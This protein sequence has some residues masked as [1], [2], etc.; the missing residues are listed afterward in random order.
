MILDTLVQAPQYNALSP[1]F[2]PAFAFL[3]QVHESTPLGRHEIAGEE[4]FA[5]VQQHATK[6]V[7]ERKFEAHRKYIDIQYIVR[8][9]ELIY[10]A[11]LP[12]LTTVTMPFDEKMDAALFAGIPEAVPLQLR[13]GHFAIL[14]PADGHAPSCAWEEPTEVLKVVVKVM[15]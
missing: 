11:P 1:R 2:A 15:V 3:R 10:W 5:F 7:A 9:R 6:P 8:G 14:F 4:V 12:L 13:P